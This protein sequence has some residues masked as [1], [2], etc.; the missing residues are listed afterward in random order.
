MNYSIYVFLDNRNKP[1]YVGKTNSMKR[2]RKE[3]LAEIEKGNPLPKYAKA[4]KLM[5]AGIKFRM[6]TIRTTKN[7]DRAYRI[8]RYF[9]KKFRRD[10]YKLYNC[11]FGGPDETPMKINK[12]RKERKIGIKLPYPKLKKRSSKIKKRAGRKNINKRRKK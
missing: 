5:R 6:R 2:R 11:T 8:E 10:G 9:I 1:Y 12:P 7:E 4:R 3:H